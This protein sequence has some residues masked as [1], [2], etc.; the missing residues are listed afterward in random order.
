MGAVRHLKDEI[1]PDAAAW[2][3]YVEPYLD[4]GWLEAPWFFAEVYFFRRILEAIGYYTPGP[5]NGVDPYLSQKRQGLEAVQPSVQAMAPRLHDWVQAEGW[6]PGNLEELIQ[7][8]LWGNQADLSL[9]PAGEGE[10]PGHEDESHQREHTLIDDTPALLAHLADLKGR[11]IQVD[12]ILDNVGLELAGDLFLADFLLGNRV[13]E[14]VN[15]HAKPHPT[16]VSDA[17]IK[18]VNE[19]LSSFAGSEDLRVRA[20]AG[21]LL[22]YRDA[23]RL[24]FATHYYWTSPLSFWEMPAPL[25]QDLGRGDLVICKGDANYRRLLGDRHWPFTTPFAD[26]VRYFPTS[27]LALRTLKSEVAAGLQPGQ[28]EEMFQKDPDWLTDGK[29]GVIQFYRPLVD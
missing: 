7:A 5:G 3:G 11:P 6:S 12:V 9:W 20:L 29:W 10:R 4:A 14:G 17:M 13:A 19:M 16:Y 1:A 26:I 21:R 28:A 18:D 8:D 23:G 22:G 25:N 27:L 24:R 2:R 15:F